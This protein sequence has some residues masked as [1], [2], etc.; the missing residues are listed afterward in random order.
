MSDLHLDF[1][2]PPEKFEGQREQIRIDKIELYSII[3]SLHSARAENCW[4]SIESLEEHLE[5]KL[6][7]GDDLRLVAGE[8]YEENLRNNK[9]WK[10]IV[11]NEQTGKEDDS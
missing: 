6:T 10:S 7:E 9:R 11:K 1:N 8:L 4:E 3:N 5:K 2:N